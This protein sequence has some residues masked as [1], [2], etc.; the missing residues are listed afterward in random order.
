MRFKFLSFFFL[1]LLFNPSLCQSAPCYGTKIPAK[2]GFFSGIEVF[3]ID[4]NLEKDQGK[5]KSTQSFLLVSYGLQDWFSIDLKVGIGG[6]DRYS[7]P[8]HNVDYSAR[9]DGGYGFRALFFD[10]DNVRLTGGFQHISVHPNTVSLDNKK[11]KAVLDDWQ[12]SLLLS[13]D[14]SHL[15]LYAG[16][17][18]SRTD[19]INW[20][21]N[22]R[23][24]HMSDSGDCIGFVC[25][26]DIKITDE[27]WLNAEAGFIDAKTAAISLMARF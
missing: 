22:A 4:R 6:I 21:D 19:Y 20:I 3:H 27:M 13:Y 17:R 5:V 24:R 8:Y 25:G 11:Y 14:Y 18:V 23:K 1:L 26:A 7:A 2:G 10:R 15:S 16:P 12:V 9:F